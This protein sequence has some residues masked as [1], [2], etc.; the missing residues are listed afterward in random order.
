M[1][2]FQFFVYK[3]N[4]IHL[5]RLLILSWFIPNVA[6]LSVCVFLR[7]WNWRIWDRGPAWHRSPH[8]HPYLQWSHRVTV[9]SNSVVLPEKKKRG[10]KPWRPKLSRQKKT[11]CAES[12]INY[13]KCCLEEWMYNILEKI[14]CSH[15]L[16]LCIFPLVCSMKLKSVR[17][18]IV[19]TI[20]SSE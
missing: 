10:K 4:G 16:Y 2:L 9:L 14:K 1:Y 18:R 6:F 19:G 7:M 5:A 17:K 12:R 20:N 11:D 15:I 3:L 8:R 13:G